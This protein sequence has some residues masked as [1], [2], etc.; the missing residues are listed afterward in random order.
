M[1]TFKVTLEKF[2]EEGKFAFATVED[3]YD[4]AELFDHCRREF[5][6]YDIIQFQE[7]SK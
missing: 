6:E 5:P 1:A 2:L 4:E 3:C 7:I